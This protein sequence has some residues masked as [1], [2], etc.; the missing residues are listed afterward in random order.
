[1][2]SLGCLLFLLILVVLA[3]EIYAIVLVGGLAEAFGGHLTII[4]LAVVLSILGIKLARWRGKTIPQAMMSGRVGHAAAGLFGAVLLVFPGLITAAFGLLLQ[5]PPIQALVAGVMQRLFMSMTAIAMK[6]MAGGGG[7]GK[8]FPGG[9]F[10]AGGFPGGMPPGMAGSAPGGVNPQQLAAAMQAMRR[11]G[12]MPGPK[13]GG[14]GPKTYD[15]QA[16]K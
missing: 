7:P 1:M 14:K 10:P 4:V 5:L 15:V 16:K 2:K 13:G 12:A 3:V 11:S 8:G 6:R 9:G